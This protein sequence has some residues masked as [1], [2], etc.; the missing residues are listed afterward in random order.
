MKALLLILGIL[1]I[2]SSCNPV[3]VPVASR[4]DNFNIRQA[5]SIIHSQ[6][7]VR[8]KQMKAARKKRNQEIKETR[9]LSKK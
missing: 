6:K 5:K 4:S 7:K 1:L 2:L 8:K 3:T 9:A